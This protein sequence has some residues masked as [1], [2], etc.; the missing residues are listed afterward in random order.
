MRRVVKPL[1]ALLTSHKRIVIKDSAVSI[2]NHLLGLSSLFENLLSSSFSPPLLSPFSLLLPFPHSSSSS[3]SIILFKV[4]AVCYGAKLLL[5]GV[6]RFDEGIEPKME[7]VA[8]TT[9]GEAV[10]LCKKNRK[11]NEMKNNTCKLVDCC[12]FSRCFN[13]CSCWPMLCI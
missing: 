11:D 6:L 3:F 2:F 13:D 10:A 4:N 12:I 7:V 9:K 1:E 8:M 5:P